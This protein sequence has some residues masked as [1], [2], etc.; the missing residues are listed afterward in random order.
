MEYI[1]GVESFSCCLYWP[2]RGEFPPSLNDSV[3]AL[4]LKNDNPTSMADW[5]PIAMCN[6]VYKIVSKVLANR[7]KLVLSKCMSIEQSAFVSF[8]IIHYLKSK[9]KGKKRVKWL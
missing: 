2:Y 8:E 6:V 3:L 5:R 9:Q 4:I 1:Y 7:L